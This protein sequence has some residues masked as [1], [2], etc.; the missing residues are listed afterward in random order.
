[1]GGAANQEVGAHCLNV[2]ALF[3]LP[4][5]QVIWNAG[6]KERLVDYL[7]TDL[8]PFVLSRSADPLTPYAYSPKSPLV[9][10]ELAGTPRRRKRHACEGAL[11]KTVPCR[12]KATR[13]LCLH[14]VEVFQC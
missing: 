11:R 1:M 2:I 4:T 12:G 3:C 7:A 13:T 5:V 9:Y 14:R 8:E 6:M 10:P